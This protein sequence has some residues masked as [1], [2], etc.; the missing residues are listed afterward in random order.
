[1]AQD[2]IAMPAAVH[3]QKTEVNGNARAAAPGATEV[4]GAK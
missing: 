3:F 2:E 4:R 1:M